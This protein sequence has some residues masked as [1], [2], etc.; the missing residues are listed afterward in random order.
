MTS[1]LLGTVALAVAFVGGGLI[2]LQAG[3]NARLAQVLGTPV[4]AACV[5]FTLGMLVLLPVAILL[6]S[7]AKAF[8]DLSTVPW[9]A[10]VGGALG[11][12]FVTA[13]IFTAP[14]VG[15][16]AMIAAVIAGQL[17]AAL[18]LDQ[19]GWAGYAAMPLGWREIAG[20]VLLVAGVAMIRWGRG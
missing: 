5:S 15:A 16:T 18:L 20:V 14:I 2:P 4:W 9:W 19:F 6:R 11:A 1:G 17:V 10:W 13:T 12:C 7:P 3:V 8:G